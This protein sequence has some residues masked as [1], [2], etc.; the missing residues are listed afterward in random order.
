M[1]VKSKLK[2]AAAFCTKPII[3]VIIVT[4][5][6]K[7]FLQHANK[8]LDPSADCEDCEADEL[9]AIATAPAPLT[10][11][12]ACVLADTAAI[13]PEPVPEADWAA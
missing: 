12:A 9:A 1:S 2:T 3:R 7:L 13:E 6:E 10:L 5:E 8:F 11:S 4:N